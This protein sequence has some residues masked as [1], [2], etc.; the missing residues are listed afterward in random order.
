MVQNI[1]LVPTFFDVAGVQAPK[2][3][4]IDGRSLEPLLRTGKTD[5]WRDH[6]YFEMGTGR[7]LLIK[8]WKYIAIRYTKD[9]VARIRKASPAQLP[10]LMCPL[11]R[12]GIGMRGV[13]HPGFWHEDQL[14]NVSKDPHEM[15]NLA[16]SPEHAPKVR[17]MREKL[18]G[19]LRMFDRPFGELIPGGDATEPGQVDDK[20]VIVRKIKVKGKNVIVPPELGG[21][22]TTDQRKNKKKK[23]K[24]K[25]KRR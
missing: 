7:A 14:Y 25:R 6:L 18:T 1:D 8:D 20:L 10:R 5:S 4:R 21:T 11:Q 24:R 3:Y 15:T 9:Q 19:V 23:R 16:N 12:M 2:N 17:E 13:D 22:Q